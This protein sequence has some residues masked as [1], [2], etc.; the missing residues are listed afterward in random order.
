MRLIPLSALTSA[1]LS[2]WAELSQRVIEPNPFFESVFLLAAWHAL[3]RG[4]ISL[5]VHA[6]GDRWKGCLPV[7][8]QRPF[9]GPSVLSSWDHP[10][11]FL[12]TPLVDRDCVDAFAQAFVRS[13]QDRDFA[14][15][16]IL[17]TAADGAV[18]AAIRAAMPETRS[19]GTI[20]EDEHERAMLVRH[21]QPDYLDALKPHRRR[22]LK[23]LR[24]RLEEELGNLE[25]CDRADDPE[26]VENFLRLEE[27]GWK[28]QGGTAMAASGDDAE[29]FR[30]MCASY[31]AADRLQLLSLQAGDQVVA[32]K[33]NIS[34][35]RTLFCFKI[36]YDERFSRYS[37]GVLLE[38]ENMRIFHEQ[39][40][41][42]LMDSCADPDNAMINRLW[43]DRRSIVTT[44]LGPRDALSW[45]VN[46]MRTA[47]RSARARREHHKRASRHRPG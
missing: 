14:R 17:R 47:I 9:R 10:Y 39:R 20:F 25:V 19:M 35:N 28:G 23:R 1:D 43:Q 18:L 24:R 22:E 27:S 5:L 26:A 4:D 29:M 36:A 8:L 46:H 11:S 40:D 6:Q 30:S 38:V 41:E 15:F 42:Q 34:A 2:S 3:G 44:M 32:M 33:C 45:T 21:A 7:Q 13:A 31:A 37:P 16:A 12:G